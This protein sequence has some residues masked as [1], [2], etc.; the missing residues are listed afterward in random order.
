M[1]EYPDITVYLEALQRRVSGGTLQRVAL[2]SPFLLR[3]AVPPIDDFIQCRVE[4]LQRIGKRIAIGFEAERWM[5]FH[6]MVAG[7]LHWKAAAA[8]AP[9]KSALICLTFAMPAMKP[10]TARHARLAVRCW[11]TARCRGC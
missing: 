9:G 10:T 1:P 5:V 6:L 4:S 11:P 2:N 8:K 3:T 7:R